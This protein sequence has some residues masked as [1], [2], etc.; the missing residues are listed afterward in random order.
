[1][2]ILN[3]LGEIESHVEDV[4]YSN[5]EHYNVQ[6]TGLR[7]DTWHVSDFTSP[8]LRKSY[9]GKYEP[10][11]PFDKKRGKILWLGNIIHEHIKLSAIN[12]LTMCYDIVDD[13]AYPPAIVANMSEEERKN[14]ITGSLDD[15]ILYNG[16]YIIGDKKTWN[17]RGWK[18]ATPD[19]N[20]VLQLN[21]YRLLL[22]ESW[23]IDASS[24]CLLY[25]DKGD[26]CNP[27]PMAFRLQDMNITKQFLKDTLKTM[28]TKEGPP[29]NPCWLCNGK[30]RE[31]KIYCDY[32]EKCNSETDREKQLKMSTKIEDMADEEILKKQISEIKSIKKMEDFQ[33]TL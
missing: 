13:I 30:N 6:N 27:K 26:D 24:G 2:L 10:K 1:M 8:C 23:K 12:E 29:I 32:W 15:L 19:S 17:A 25:L 3:E 31:G 5:I 28:Q 21:I 14:I 33:S 18:K 11:P 22:W 4:Y 9:Y 20:Y 16:E 7:I